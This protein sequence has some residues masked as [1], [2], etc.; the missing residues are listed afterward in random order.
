M[1]N[2]LPTQKPKRPLSVWFV[3]IPLI[4]LVAFSF[5]T[6]GY[7]FVQYPEFMIERSF[8]W[9]IMP[10]VKTSFLLLVSIGLFRRWNWSR[11]TASAILIFFAVSYLMSPDDEDAPTPIAD[12]MEVSTEDP[13]YKAGGTLGKLLFAGTLLSGAALLIFGKRPKDYFKP[14]ESNK[15]VVTTPNAAR[16]TS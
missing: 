13:S 2:N 5:I 1:D 16:P 8:D 4:L 7:R 11:W 3:G 10:I 9:L 14:T 6:I 12:A 15:S